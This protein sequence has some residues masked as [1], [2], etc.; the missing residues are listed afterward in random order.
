[1]K[2]KLPL[3]LGIVFVLFLVIIISIYMYSVSLSDN[4]ALK[5]NLRELT[6]LENIESFKESIDTSA[7]VVSIIGGQEASTPTTEKLSIEVNTTNDKALVTNSQNQ[8]LELNLNQYKEQ[9]TPIKD[10]AVWEKLIDEGNY[11]LED[12]TLE[13]EDVWKYTIKNE[14]VT[15]D[16][17]MTVA[18]SLETQIKGMFMLQGLEAK[19]IEV[20][21][22]G[23]TEFVIYV[24][25]SDYE[26]KSATV[27]ADSDVMLT[28]TV[29]MSGQEIP[30]E[31]KIQDFTVN[32]GVSDYELKGTAKSL[33]RNP[34]F[35]WIG[36]LMM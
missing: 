3:V 35:L 27:T 32:F 15:N 21:F 34:L 2:Q 31:V 11:K 8:T 26:M 9:F 29:V 22:E 28:L 18:P 5:S 14:A 1:M 24:G 12:A 7:N 36:S 6:T 30:A 17:L 25:K 19:D 33:P 10:F 20:K 4:L 13:G 23:D 16:Y